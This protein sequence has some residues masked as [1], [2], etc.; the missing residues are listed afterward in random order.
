MRACGGRRSATDLSNQPT[1]LMARLHALAVELS[2]GGIAKGLS[3]TDAAKFRA[4]ITPTDRVAQLRQELIGEIATD[5]A[6]EN[7]WWRSARRV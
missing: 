1:W 5:I 4:T 6:N 2:P 7:G 3:S